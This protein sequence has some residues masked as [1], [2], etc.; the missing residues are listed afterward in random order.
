[1]SAKLEK[2]LMLQCTEFFTHKITLNYEKDKAIKDLF[3][4]SK[5]LRVADDKYGLQTEVSGE[6]VATYVQEKNKN[7]DTNTK[8]L[9]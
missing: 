4:L 3:F 8:N 2:H 7:Q 9:S 5:T 6:A 1:M